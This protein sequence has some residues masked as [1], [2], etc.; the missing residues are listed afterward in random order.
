[1]IPTTPNTRLNPP[2]SGPLSRQV[3]G[4]R[5][6]VGPRVVQLNS[7]VTSSLEREKAW[8][9][10]Q[11]KLS[12]ISLIVV[13]SCTICSASHVHTW[14]HFWHVLCAN[15]ITMTHTINSYT[16]RLSINIARTHTQMKKSPRGEKETGKEMRRDRVKERIEQ[17]KQGRKWN[18]VSEKKERQKKKEIYKKNK[19]KVI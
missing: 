11:R 5:M 7:A 13:D 3:G 19:N 4:L 12:H 15:I 16:N 18:K 8:D 9:A 10:K 6:T 17:R 1:M 14:I 2:V